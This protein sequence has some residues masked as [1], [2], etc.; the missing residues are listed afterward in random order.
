MSDYLADPNLQLS[1]SQE[2][3][4]QALP[5]SINSYA[6]QFLRSQL[7][8]GT[9][10]FLPIQGLLQVLTVPIDQIIGMPHMPAW[11]MGIYNWRGEVLWVIDLGH[12]CGLL[13]WHQQP[14][15]LTVHRVVVLRSPKSEGNLTAKDHRLGLAVGTIEDMEWCNVSEIQEPTP[16]E[17]L[18]QLTP[19]LR[20][21]RLF[22]EGKLAVLDEAAIFAAM[23]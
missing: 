1:P 3:N 14:T 6:E 23:P 5:P 21:W 18:P 8:P 20:G 16:A 22:Q 2:Q 9:T 19:F 15:P 13:P 11:V 17:K 10:I 12:L 7:A 4:S